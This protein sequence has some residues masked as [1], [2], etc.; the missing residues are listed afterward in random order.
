LSACVV[1]FMQLRGLIEAVDMSCVAN[2]L[3]CNITNPETNL[4][5]ACLCFIPSD[6]NFSFFSFH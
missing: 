4:K 2:L 1:V 3:I 5:P 6:S